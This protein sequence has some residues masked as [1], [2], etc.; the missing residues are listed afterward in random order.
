MG[1]S[2]MQAIL[3]KQRN[4]NLIMNVWRVKLIKDTKF[5]NALWQYVLFGRDSWLRIKPICKIGFCD[6]DF[7]FQGLGGRKRIGT[8]WIYIPVDNDKL[9]VMPDSVFHYFYV[10]RIA[11]SKKFRNAVIYGAKPESEEYIAKVKPFYRLEDVMG[12]ENNAICKYCGK[13]LLGDWAFMKGHQGNVK[14]YRDSFWKELIKPD[15]TP[16]GWVFLCYNCLHYTKL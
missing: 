7:T 5:L 9:Y 16:P 15:D 14:I 4:I 10:H 8:G 1:E 11:P 13:P 3:I 6:N 2:C 12:Y